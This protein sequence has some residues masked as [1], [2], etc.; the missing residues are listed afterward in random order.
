MKLWLV[1]YAAGQVGGTWGPLPYDMDR[2]IEVRDERQAAIQLM[3]YTGVGENGS[4]IPAETIDKLKTWRLEC[5][6]RHARPSA[7]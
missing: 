6:Q 1:L 7:S 4:P 3:V 5:E 2:C